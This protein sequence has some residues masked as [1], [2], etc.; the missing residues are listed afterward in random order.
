MSRTPANPS[1]RQ[2]RLTATERRE[3]EFKEVSEARRRYVETLKQRVREQR[4][5]LEI[6]GV[7][8]ADLDLIMA[9]LLRLDDPSRRFFLYPREGGGYGF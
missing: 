7:D 1:P 6:P 8:P 3:A 5:K 2:K 4:G 9:S